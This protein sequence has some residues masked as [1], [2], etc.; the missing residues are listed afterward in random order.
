MLIAL[1]VRGADWPLYAIVRTRSQ[2]QMLRESLTN[3]DRTLCGGRTLPKA[4][5]RLPL[6]L[7]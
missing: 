2:K 4:F 3:A 7:P 5:V 1:V 6:L